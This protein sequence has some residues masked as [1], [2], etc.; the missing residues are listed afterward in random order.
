[1]KGFLLPP[2]TRIPESRRFLI[3]KLYR[4]L[5]I[6][7]F[8][9]DLIRLILMISLFS[10]F[11]LSLAGEETGVFPYLVYA[12][13]H[14]LFP[15]MTLFLWLQYSAY[16]SY[17]FLYI[18]GKAIG[19]VSIFAWII[20]SFQNILV[21]LAAGTEGTPVIMGSALFLAAI[22]ALSIWGGVL[23]KNKLYRTELPAAAV[24]ENAPEGRGI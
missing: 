15:L 9:Y 14:A 12:A 7:L 16:E 10:V 23:L 20:S 5:R 3:M 2:L 11:G 8:L 19:I 18:A 4:P 6:S 17:I 22:D 1:M 13:A 24:E 21:S